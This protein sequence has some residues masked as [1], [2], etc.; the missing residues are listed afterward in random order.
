MTPSEILTAA[1][2]RVRDLAAAAKPGPW[3]LY[4]R[5]VCWEIPE[6]PEMHDGLSG[7]REGDARWISALSPAIAEPLSRMLAWASKVCADAEADGWDRDRIWAES[8]DSMRAALDLAES[9]LGSGV[10]THE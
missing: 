6:L 3:T 2:D 7:F 10:D 9:I 1:A 5:G 4:D 8:D